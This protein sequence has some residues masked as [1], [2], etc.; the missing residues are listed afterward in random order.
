[1]MVVTGGGEKAIDIV[2]N[3]AKPATMQKLSKRIDN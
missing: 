1:M 3:A 2:D